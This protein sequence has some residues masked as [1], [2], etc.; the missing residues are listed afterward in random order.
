VI[1]VEAPPKAATACPPRRA[2][3]RGRRWPLAPL[4]LI[5]SWAVAQPTAAASTQ[6]TSLQAEA[7]QL[8]QELIQKQ[9][10]V[11]VL[12]HQ[13]ELDALRVAQDDAALAALQQQIVA[14]R[15][16]V[17]EDR[18]RLSQEAVSAYVNAGAS[19][20]NPALALFGA[21]RQSALSRSEYEDV[22]IGDTGTTL[23][24]LHLD[25]VRLGAAQGALE[26][27]AAQ[28]RAAEAAERAAAG[29]A[30]Q[31]ADQLAA[32]QALVTSQLAV[33]IAAERIG[34]AASAVAT[35]AGAGGA[36]PDPPLPPFLQCVVQVESGGDYQAV[37]PN[38]LYMGAFQFSQ[39]TWNLAAQLAGLPQLIG[40]P[41]NEA[42]KADQ[43]TL[44][45]ALWQADGS[46][47]WTG[48]CGS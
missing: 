2:R 17:R 7:A 47:P 23:A 30:Q 5:A 3:H 36:V 8:S 42:S 41:P 45:V 48:D 15:T 39:S 34:Q 16:R 25:Q 26:L 9:L 37:S 1:G 24:L 22:A 32:K 40:V 29:A 21:G 11:D 20:L 14:D 13:E 12:G 28:D 4:L 18:L 44:A 27:R 43:D 19:T 31:A 33:A 38:G 35:R 6:T 10:Q 46:Q